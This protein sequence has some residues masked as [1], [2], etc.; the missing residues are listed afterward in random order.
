VQTGAQFSQ[1]LLHRRSLCNRVTG[2]GG[3][4]E[5][6]VAPCRTVQPMVNLR[7]SGVFSAPAPTVRT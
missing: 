6:S 3:W 5:I 2:M 7:L 1:G 4:H